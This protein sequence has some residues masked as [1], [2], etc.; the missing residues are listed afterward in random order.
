MLRTVVFPTL[1]VTVVSQ[2]PLLHPVWPSARGQEGKTGRKGDPVHGCIGDD[3]P[4][5]EFLEI[6]TFLL[7]VMPFFYDPLYLSLWLWEYKSV[8]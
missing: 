2:M 4:K 1:L 6:F 7:V 5:H 3:R 8:K